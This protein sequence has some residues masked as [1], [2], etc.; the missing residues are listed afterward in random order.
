MRQCILRALPWKI[1]SLIPM[2]TF[3]EREKTG[4]MW[5]VRRAPVHSSH[6]P[7]SNGHKRPAII[8][9]FTVDVS[10][11]FFLSLSLSLFLSLSLSLSLSRTLTID[12][13]QVAIFYSLEAEGRKRRPVAAII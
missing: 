11:S 10:L 2:I 8:G 3:R 12:N 13:N 1:S 9:R 5:T 4:D 6:R 7:V